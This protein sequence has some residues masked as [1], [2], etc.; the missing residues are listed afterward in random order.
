ML[1]ISEINKRRRTIGNLI[2]PHQVPDDWPDDFF[3]DVM[4]YG[5]TLD[6][7]QNQKAKEYRRRAFYS[8][9]RALAYDKV[10]EAVHKKTLFYR[11]L[12]LYF[13][14]FW[15]IIILAIHTT[16]ISSSISS[17]IALIIPSGV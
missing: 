3:D 2:K 5:S 6:K 4:E 11:N 13:L 15:C 17:T 7:T 10:V 8:T 14:L 9:L 1:N 12:V 16:T